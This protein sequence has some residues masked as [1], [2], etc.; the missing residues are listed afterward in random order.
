[1]TP[2]E[3][4]FI[5]INLCTKE[6]PS[7]IYRTKNL[8][9]VDILYYTP[10]IQLL[11]EKNLF[12]P[13][14]YYEDD[15][16]RLHLKEPLLFQKAVENT[17]VM[18]PGNIIEL[19]VYLEEYKSSI[20]EVSIRLLI[21]SLSD[22]LF[23]FSEDEKVW[24]LTNAMRYGGALGLYQLEVLKDFCNN[25]GYSKILIGVGN[26]DYAYILKDTPKNQDTI[27]YL[28]EKISDIMDNNGTLEHKYL[29]AYNNQT[30]KLIR[31]S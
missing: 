24:C 10:D 18:L 21:H 12:S 16:K 20:Y 22:K 31:I 5:L 30:N 13:I 11:M 29:F 27:V 6:T 1:M 2:D 25:K 15:V 3:L 28:L 23:S 26:R 19:A 4:D 14:Y 8:D 7:Y 17:S 9:A